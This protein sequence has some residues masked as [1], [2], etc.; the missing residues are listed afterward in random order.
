[1]SM[2]DVVTVSIAV[3]SLGVS[4]WAVWVAKTEPVRARRRAQRDLVRGALTD[5][6]ASLKNA[7]STLARGGDVGE[8]P[9]DVATGLAVT[10]SYQSRLPETDTLL[11]MV[12][13][14]HHVILLWDTAA[15]D[16]ESVREDQVRET[17]LEQRMQAVSHQ[18]D[19]H[20]LLQKALIEQRLESEE[21]KRRRDAGHNELRDKVAKLESSIE[22]YIGVLDRNDRLGKG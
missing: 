15:H 12:P 9:D 18:T 1:M 11:S 17:E 14:F 7:R 20:S 2:S 5:A 16:E 4:I 13:R 21:K 10:Q 19:R 6:L 3:L 22:S 8:P